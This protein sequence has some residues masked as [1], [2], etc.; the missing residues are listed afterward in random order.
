MK[1]PRIAALPRVSF[2]TVQD[3]QRM[4]IT[5]TTMHLREVGH[6]ELWGALS[7]AQ[8]ALKQCW[9]IANRDSE[10]HPAEQPRRKKAR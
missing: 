2:D 10:P 8:A 4:E 1:T 9:F 6:S 5:L 7:V 3:L